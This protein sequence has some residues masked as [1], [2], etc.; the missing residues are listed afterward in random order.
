[1]LTTIIVL[2][3][4][5]FLAGLIDSISGG[6]GLLLVP[7]L[8]LAGLPPQTALGT[9]KFAATLGTATALFNFIRGK[10]VMWKIAFYGIAFALMGSYVGTKTILAFDHTAAGKILVFI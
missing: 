1:M 4:V 7:S 3:F 5:S 2:S 9:N 8:L 10:K 6:G